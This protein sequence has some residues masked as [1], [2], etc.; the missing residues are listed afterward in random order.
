MSFF[1]RMFIGTDREFG[2]IEVD[3]ILVEQFQLSSITT[4]HPVDLGADITDH[5]I[6][7]PRLYSL[8][9]VV[10]D[11]PM[12]LL[13]AAQQIGNTVNAAYSF[14]KT[15][16]LGGD[17]DEG[18]GGTSRSLA[19]FQALVELWRARQTFDIQTSLDLITDLAILDIQ[20]MVDEETAGQLRFV[21]RMKQI[22][23]VAITTTADTSANLQ[24]GPVEQSGGTVRKEG[25][26]QKVSKVVNSISDSVA[27]FFS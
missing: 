15:N 13:A 25:L 20:V 11:T 24:E 22:R 9:A 1:S 8:E 5:I 26:K 21:V 3:A 4:D 12:G 7:L 17:D 2:G 14:I 23:R 6:N 19:A 27:D 10:T 16:L 18:T